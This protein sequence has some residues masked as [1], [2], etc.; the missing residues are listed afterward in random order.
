MRWT[1]DLMMYKDFLCYIL[2]KYIIKWCNC[3][4]D[5]NKSMQG[6]LPVGTERSASMRCQMSIKPQVTC[7]CIDRACERQACQPMLP[8]SFF[9]KC[10]AWFNLL[11]HVFLDLLTV[12]TSCLWTDPQT[13]N[14]SVVS[15]L[16]EWKRSGLKL[17]QWSFTA[18]LY[19]A[20]G[21]LAVPHM[22]VKFAASIFWYFSDY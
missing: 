17:V 3:T 21:S 14:L 13:K 19:R 6:L 7:Q 2:T 4:S 12:Y 20:V 15:V 8:L 10:A 5:L 9:K 22:P 11:F 16:L 18:L 1:R